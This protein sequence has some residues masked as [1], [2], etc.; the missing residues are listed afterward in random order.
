MLIIASLDVLSG[1]AHEMAAAPVRGSLDQGDAAKYQGA[2]AGMG[3][4]CP[5]LY[6][7]GCWGCVCTDSG[8]YFGINR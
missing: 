3:S 8:I 6:L 4:I 2:A 1:Q 7:D 5:N